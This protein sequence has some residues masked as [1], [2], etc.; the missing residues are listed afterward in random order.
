M[1]SE[2]FLY[3]GGTG[4]LWGPK[5]RR[6]PAGG[7]GMPSSLV[8]TWCLGP[9]ERR[10]R[11]EIPDLISINS[12]GHPRSPGRPIAR[13]IPREVGRRIQL[14][15]KSP[16]KSRSQGKP[17]GNSTWHFPGSWIPRPGSQEIPRRAQQPGNSPLDFPGISGAAAGLRCFLP[18]FRRRKCAKYDKD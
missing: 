8:I 1:E 5:L 11:A 7:S 2:E 14:P 3:R 9:P 13:G 12:H 4:A 17:P 15:R 10:R 6:R 16:G 18:F